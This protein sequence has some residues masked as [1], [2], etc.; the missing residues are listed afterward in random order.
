[1]AQVKDCAMTHGT[2]NTT[3]IASIGTENCRS[4]AS[5]S[6]DPHQLATGQATRCSPRPIAAAIRADL[7]GLAVPK[8]LRKCRQLK[9]RSFARNHANVPG[10]KL[11][12]RVRCLGSAGEK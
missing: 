2:T 10:G 12:R 11:M 6:T 5:D 9:R 3:P 8:R 4:V 1:M 7:I